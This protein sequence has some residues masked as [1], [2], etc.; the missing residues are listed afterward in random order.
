M[1]DDDRCKHPK[2]SPDPLP[3]PFTKKDVERVRFV[4][5][6]CPDCRALVHVRRVDR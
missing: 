3:T 1:S 4:L 6:A 5:L 2:L